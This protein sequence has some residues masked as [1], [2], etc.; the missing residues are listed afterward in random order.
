MKANIK[1]KLA[2]LLLLFVSHNVEARPKLKDYHPSIPD[3]VTHNLTAIMAGNYY[4]LVQYYF[5]GIP[6]CGATGTMLT[7]IMLRRELKLSE[8]TTIVASCF[9]PIVGGMIAKSYFAKHP[10]WD[11]LPLKAQPLNL[12]IGSQS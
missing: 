1:I 2:V 6:W 10:E 11:L 5:M 3:P 12:G 9:L 8:A 7:S 4:L